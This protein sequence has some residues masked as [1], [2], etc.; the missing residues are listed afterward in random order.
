[1]SSFKSGLIRS[2][3]Q[4]TSLTYSWRASTKH[5]GIAG[6]YTHSELRHLLFRHDKG[7]H[8][9]LDQQ[10][11]DFIIK[12][13][14]RLQDNRWADLRMDELFNFD[15]SFLKFE[16]SWTF[17][18]V[19]TWLFFAF[20]ERNSGNF[21]FLFSLNWMYFPVVIFCQLFPDLNNRNGYGVTELVIF[22]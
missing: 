5:F 4:M 10:H 19:L 22:E 20:F 13:L 8:Q 11:Q 16:L 18:F 21:K 9:A 1:M 15:F 7:P 2:Y 12:H 6:I 14:S 17:V 3:R